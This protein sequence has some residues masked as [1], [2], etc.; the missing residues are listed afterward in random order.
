MFKLLGK[1][2]KKYTGMIIL[3]VILVS[4]E[5]II[6]VY[7]LAREMQSIIDNGVSAQDMDAIFKCGAK[8]V[9]FSLLTGVFAL[10]AAY[11]SAKITAGITS[12]VRAAC[13]HKVLHMTPQD[14]SH[15]G[16]STLLSRTVADATQIQLLVIN[17]MRTSLMV[18]IVIVILLVSVFLQ[19]RTI[20]VVMAVVF[21]FVVAFL[22]IF[23][24]RSKP[25]FHELQN[26]QDRLNL[27]VG[28]KITGART[29]RSFG[30]QEYEE[31]RLEEENR[32]AYEMAIRA[33]NRINFLSPVSLVA[34]NW[35][36]VIIYWIGSSQ[37]K[38][39]LATVSG[40]LV[41]FQYVS[42]FATTLSV[43]PTLLN[44]I[45]KVLVSSGRINELLCYRAENEYSG[46]EKTENVA[47]EIEFRDVCFGY[48]EGSKTVSNL[49]FTARAGKTT[50]FI[51]ATGSGKTT[52]MNLVMGF[53]KPDSG[54]VLLDGKAY[55]EIEPD[56]RKKFFSYAPQGAGVF[57][58][59]AYRNIT[60]YD[61]DISEERVKEACRASC[62]DE[63]I[64]KMPE[65]LNTVMAQ[66]GK[67]ISGGQRQRLSLARTVA[68]DAAVYIFDDTFSALDAL[69]ERK[70]REQINELLKGKTILMV[71]QK[72]NTIRDADRILVMDH[73][74]IVAGGTHE[75]LLK[76]CEIYQE[77]YRTQ[78]YLEGEGHE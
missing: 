48:E 33:N 13:F 24:L 72:I 29:I 76:S 5:M 44:L 58:D 14:F 49:S 17:F 75:E 43:I 32:K 45:P 34:M 47:G 77:I 2:G 10:G 6:Q 61:E 9:F 52:V 67:N 46:K 27:V 63:V 62:F 57:R 16:D 69:T 36:V 38:Q 12:D 7:F 3:N 15:F 65:G 42:Y 70:S 73:G 41:I 23:G 30:N 4:I 68:K 40:L 64:E 53:F 54:T 19:N 25:Y 18:P 39:G 60:M 78:C 74:T 21:A 26:Q 66:G 59:T 71:A 35:T 11:F 1:F 37:L 8:M 56:E 28:E 20:F 50:A 22:V 51:G 31:K 55:D